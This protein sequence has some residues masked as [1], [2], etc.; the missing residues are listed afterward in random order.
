MLL[1]DIRRTRCKK[2]LLD[3]Q[4]SSS[5]FPLYRTQECIPSLHA[6]NMCLYQKFVEQ[7]PHPTLY[8]YSGR[9][10]VVPPSTVIVTPVIYVLESLASSSKGA[11]KSWSAFPHLCAGT[12][13]FAFSWTRSHTPAVISD[14]NKPGAMQFARMPW[15]PSSSARV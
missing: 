3:A 2:L 5:G 11:V 9:F 10:N 4:V 15:G 12:T 13:A 14:S 8:Q 7:H 1:P 6:N